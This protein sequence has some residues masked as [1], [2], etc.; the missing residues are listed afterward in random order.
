[1]RNS[2][3]VAKWEIKR[4]VKNKSFLIGLFLTPIIMIGF[5][6]IGGWISGSSDD[7]E[8]YDEEMTV[9]VHD[10]LDIFADLEE[11]VAKNGLSWSLEETDVT[12]DDMANELTDNEHVAYVYLDEEAIVDGTITVYTSDE[13]DS[14]FIH[15]V[16]IFQ[17]PIL[18]YQMDQLGLTAAQSQA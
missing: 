11:T 10:E 9:F 3:K 2:M 7:T 16:D 1:M 18:A 12:E 8:E 5:G 4:N 14:F 17:G 13:V 15:Q 6:L